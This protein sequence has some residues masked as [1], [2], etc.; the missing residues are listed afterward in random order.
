MRKSILLNASK[1]R[2]YFDK[3]TPKPLK[4]RLISTSLQI[5]N[6]LNIIIDF[7]FYHGRYFCI[8]L[9]FSVHLLL[10][11]KALT[12]LSHS[13]GSG[14]KI[15]FKHISECLLLILFTGF[16]LIVTIKLACR[17]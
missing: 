2:R 6:K 12:F 3:E 10:Y 15:G 17:L 1:I 5:E 4:T 13:F 8:L 9:D 16:K 7:I 14:Y 11:S